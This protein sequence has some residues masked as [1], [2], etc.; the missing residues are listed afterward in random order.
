[1]SA[2]E[3]VACQYEGNEMT[4][5]FKAP[6]MIEVL[7]NLKSD[8]VVLNLSDPTRPGIFVPS[9]QLDDENI[10]MLLMPMQT[11]DY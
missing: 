2:E 11:F 10:L 4:I 5:G 8:E 7:S 9:K 6:F 3:D 1:M